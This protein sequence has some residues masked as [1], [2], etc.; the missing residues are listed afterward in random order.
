MVKARAEKAANPK[1]S[2]K[3]QEEEQAAESKRQQKKKRKKRRKARIKW[4][5][6]NLQAHFK[7]LGFSPVHFHQG[8]GADF[9]WRKQLFFD[10]AT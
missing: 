6:W 3:K 2:K 5:D 10:L 9:N 7:T 1:K 4:G 8:F